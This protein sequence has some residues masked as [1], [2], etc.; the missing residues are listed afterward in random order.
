MPLEIRSAKEALVLNDLKV[1]LLAAVAM[2]LV[3]SPGVRAEILIATA[4]PFT[5]QNIFR[6]EQIQQGAEMA[7]ADINAD[8]GVLGQRVELTLADDACDPEQ[9]VAVAK[10]LV[11]DGVVFVAG[12]VCSHSSIPASQV[13]EQAG[14]LMISPASTNPRLTDEGDDNVFR[15]C[16]RDDQQGMVAGDYL[17]DEWGDKKIAILHDGST[18]GKGLADETLKQLNKRGVQEAMYE[19]Y[20]PG[21]RDYSELVSRLDA[22]GID[23]VYIGGYSSEAGLM[24]RQARDQGYGAQI[25][26]GDALT[27]DEF[28]MIT[29]PAGEGT[30]VTFGPDPRAN[31]EAGP[32]VKRFRDQGFEPSGYTLHTYAAVQVWAQA[33]EKAR[34]LDLKAVIASL[35]SHVFQTVLGEIGFDDK[36]DVTAPGYVWYVWKNGEY[37]P[38]E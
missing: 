27:N 17:A 35:R 29:G 36:G 30:L 21:G 20:A 28:W 10:K 31:A 24:V 37:V 12:H 7:V 1:A 19:A 11:S 3:G 13:Y 23:V 25:V 18:Y 34:S 32:V 15:V 14:V 33:V 9:A 8:G 4:G 5:G 6:G 38:L 2:T 22:A 26:S 16:G